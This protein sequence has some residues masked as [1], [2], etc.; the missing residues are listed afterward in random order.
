MRIYDIILKKRDGGEL[1][2]EEIEAIVGGYA[3]GEVS[4]AQAAAWLMA[5]CF[6]GMTPRET[7]DLTMT[8]VHSG[9]VLDLSYIPG[10]KIDKHSTGGVGDKT[11]LVLVPLWAGA[12]VPVA[13]MSGRSLGHT[14]GTADKLEAIP[15]FRVALTPEEVIS[16]V[17]RV[18]AV[19]ATQTA[20]LTPADKKLYALRDLTAT[21]DCIPLIAASVMSKKIASCA[22]AILLDVKVGSGAFMKTLKEARELASGMVEIGRQVGRETVAVITDMEQPLGRAVG[23]AIE[24]REAVEVLNGGGPD[25]LV[26]LC[27][28]L[29]GLGL[30]LGRK[31]QTPEDGERIIRGMLSDGR[32]AAK[33]R[34]IIEAQGG[35]PSV[36]D[37]PSVLPQAPLLRTVPAPES[38]FV[39]RLD[40]MEVAR[41]AVELGC[42]RSAAG[43]QP[44]LS[45]GILLRAKI[46]ESIRSGEPLADIHAADNS[47]ADRAAVILRGA[48]RFGP[49]PIARIPLV[50]EVIRRR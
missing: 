35:D 13:K 2:A 17:T 27:V 4:D 31:A 7:A 50:R 48:F 3:R 11:T 19:M 21:V 20:D 18:G 43:Y 5:V 12:G 16:Q 33:L 44:D 34:G 37:D 41:A 10:T 29:G 32:G 45:A 14:G 15:G 24:V 9:E 22:D 1:T 47:S 39:T 25:D 40:A 23:N 46:G 6:R 30:V 38:G 49:S 36:V 42:G 26:E 28:I 8:M